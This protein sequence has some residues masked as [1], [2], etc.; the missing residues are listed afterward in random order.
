MV[1]TNEN[2]TANSS[3]S[4]P[5]STLSK[6]LDVQ[7][8]VD[9]YAGTGRVIP[10]GKKFGEP[11]SK[12]RISSDRVIG[13]YYDAGLQKFIPTK[14]FIIHYSKKGVHIVPARP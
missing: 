10:G 7:K 3:S 4:T 14:N 5:R 8:I 2:K 12:E 1:G 6:D 11:G 9:Q 13:N